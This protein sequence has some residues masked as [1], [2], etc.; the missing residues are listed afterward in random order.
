MKLSNKALSCLLALL[1]MI[2]TVTGCEPQFK[3]SLSSSTATLEDPTEELFST[4][5]PCD[6]TGGA[7]S[8]DATDSSEDVTESSV[9]ED[10]TEAPAGGEDQ[11]E[12]RIMDD[13]LWIWILIAIMIVAVCA[14]A[15]FITVK[16]RK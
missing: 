16:V 9:P 1:L 13:S 14:A 2:A 11:P 15:G 5:P 6:T 3:G 12:V 10:T 7:P 4:A 8:E